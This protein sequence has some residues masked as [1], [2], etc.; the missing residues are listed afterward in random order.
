[1]DVK[2]LTVSQ[3]EQISTIFDKLK[4][5]ESDI[6]LENFIN[7]KVLIRA[8]RNGVQVGIVVSIDKEF[9][10]LS[11]SRKLWR[12][13]CAEGIALESLAENGIS[14]GTK[15]TKICNHTALRKDDICGIITLTNEIYSQI[16]DW[17]SAKQEQDQ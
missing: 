7:K 13:K 14:E 16:M 17:P 6:S 8:H 15:A 11:P 12:W 2:N 5:S 9:I 3:L 1:M 10:N 4:N